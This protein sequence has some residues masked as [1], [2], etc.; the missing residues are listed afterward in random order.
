MQQLL[1]DLRHYIEDLGIEGSESA[2]SE[3]LTVPSVGP[4]RIIKIPLYALCRILGPN[5]RT[6]CDSIPEVRCS[7]YA[8]RN[9]LICIFFGQA[10]ACWW[11]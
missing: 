7:A 10:R 5:I 8:L 9:F 6:F 11:W 2:M 1:L 4:L 3:R